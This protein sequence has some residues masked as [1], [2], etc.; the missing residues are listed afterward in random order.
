MRP[1]AWLACAIAKGIFIPGLALKLNSLRY[2]Q[3]EHVVYLL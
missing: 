1:N 3:Y 2:E